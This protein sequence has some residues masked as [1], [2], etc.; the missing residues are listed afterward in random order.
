MESKSKG[1]FCNAID[2]GFDAKMVEVGIAAQCKG[3]LDLDIKVSTWV[4]A[5]VLSLADFFK[6]F[7]LVDCPIIYNLMPDSCNGC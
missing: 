3:S 4:V 1:F 6:A 5:G 7:A 2:T